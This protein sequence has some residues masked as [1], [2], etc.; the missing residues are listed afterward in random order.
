MFGVQPCVLVLITEAQ[1]C[2]QGPSYQFFL[3]VRDLDPSGMLRT[4]LPAVG[5]SQ[6]CPP[7]WFPGPRFLMLSP[8][9]LLDPFFPSTL[10][11]L[12]TS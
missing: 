6:L 4:F 5:C 9:D 11:P 7:A 3:G 1:L 12:C 8:M 10:A 2:S